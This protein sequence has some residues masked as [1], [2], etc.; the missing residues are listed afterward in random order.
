MLRLT[1]P[2]VEITPP[3]VMLP[4]PLVAVTVPV[5]VAPPNAMMPPA[6][7]KVS[8]F[9][10][11]VCEPATVI[12]PEPLRKVTLSVHVRAL[13]VI[14]TVPLVRPKS[15]LPHPSTMRFKSDVER[16]NVPAPPATP[17]VC[18]LLAC[19]IVIVPVPEMLALN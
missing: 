5:P 12:L 11:I 19:W 16:F 2:V 4:P 9:A 7:D 17:I 13:T 1:A 14:N 18:V 10:P 6:V 8:A 3:T 15:M